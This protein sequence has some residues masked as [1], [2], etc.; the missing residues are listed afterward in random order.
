[1][2]VLALGM[3]AS[4]MLAEDQ[5]DAWVL[6]GELR[7]GLTAAAQAASF[8]QHFLPAGFATGDQESGKLYLSLPE[9]VRWD[10]LLPYPKTFL[11]CETTLY[12][13]N[14]GD[15]AGRRLLLP[16]SDQPG[17]DLLRLQLDDL[18]QR[19]LAEVER[20]LDGSTEVVLSP[21]SED[22]EIAEA[23]LTIDATGR[24][25]KALSYRDRE[26]NSSRFEITAYQSLVDGGHFD[27]PA[28][29]EWFDQ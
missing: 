18:R 17:V 14:P 21:R 29:I 20:S 26:G 13:W 10:Y 16:D 1:M 23:R 19:Y 8:V 7:D 4:P 28:D 9:C 2:L 24:R 27:P 15:E 5:E 6:L 3:I 22:V 25:L 11:F 12:T